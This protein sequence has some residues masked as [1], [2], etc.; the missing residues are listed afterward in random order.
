MRAKERQHNRVSELMSSRYYEPLAIKLIVCLSAVYPV[1][2]NRG[3]FGEVSVL[4][5]LEPALAGDVMPV[6]GNITFQEGEYLK[7][8]TL[9][10][11][12][13]EVTC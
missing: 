11:V 8:L 1:V 5:V 9:S 2:R 6:Q 12:P 13:D 4:W 7:N 3:H 10:S